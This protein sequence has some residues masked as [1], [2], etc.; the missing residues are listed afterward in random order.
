M[1]VAWTTELTLLAEPHHHHSGLQSGSCWLERKAE[2]SSCPYL[3]GVGI[4]KGM[5][6]L[7]IDSKDA[8]FAAI[9]ERLCAE[10]LRHA[11][12]AIASSSSRTP[13]IVDCLDAYIGSTHR[14]SAQSP[15]I[16]VHMAPCPPATRLL[17]KNCCSVVLRPYN[18]Q[19]PN[20]AVRRIIGSQS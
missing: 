18:H 3:Y 4:A 10:M 2:K 12:E 11:E 8:L 19:F 20:Q 14:L 6:Y 9:A 15:H 5:L 13:R 17:L 7:Y 1:K 16:D